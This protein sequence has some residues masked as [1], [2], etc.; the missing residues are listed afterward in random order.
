MRRIM[1]LMAT[2]LVC[3]A[4]GIGTAEDGLTVVSERPTNISQGPGN[5]FAKSRV[6]KDEA[7]EY[8]GAT[9]QDDEGNMWHKVRFG[10]SFRW[11]TA[12]DGCVVYNGEEMS[13]EKLIET[14]GAVY[15]RSAPG[16]ANEAV[17]TA[18]T[19]DELI[20]IGEYTPFEGGTMWYL[21]V[22]PDGPAWLSARYA[23]PVT[24]GENE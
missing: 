17:A 20:C 19:G 13:E 14:T 6:W 7:F 8:A 12:E 9:V 22:S 16:Q 1:I 11:I 24:G 23:R 4:C 18:Q 5:D 10:D 21:V 3:F 15:L 2:L